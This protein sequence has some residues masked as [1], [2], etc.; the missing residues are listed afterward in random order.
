[1][2]AKTFIPIPGIRSFAIMMNVSDLIAGGA[3]T[4]G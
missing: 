1:M 2:I 4:S 3:R